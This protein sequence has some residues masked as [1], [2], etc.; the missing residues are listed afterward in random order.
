VIRLKGAA[1]FKSALLGTISAE[2]AATRA[3][4]AEA[5]HLIER[6]A[7]EKLAEKSHPPGTRT[8]S[9]PGEPPALV[10]GNLRRSISVFG[11]DPTTVGGFPG[12][13]A[14]IGPT[15]VYGRVQELGGDAGRAMLPPRPY[16]QPA[17]DEVHPLLRG[18]FVK[19]WRGPLKL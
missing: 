14:R 10:T 8:P 19:H 9:A 1:E 3:A 2:Q 12:W 18:I 6:T 17:Y 4:V 13:T 11:P 16:M 7:K 15:A 5:A